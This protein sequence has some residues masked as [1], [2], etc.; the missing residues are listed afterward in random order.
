MS[1]SGHPERP[2]LIYDGE[3]RNVKDVDSG[4]PYKDLDGVYVRRTGSKNDDLGVG[5]P[6]RA[7]GVPQEGVQE[8]GE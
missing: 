3:I 7:C 4:A 6:A 5:K 1:S 8:H 2:K